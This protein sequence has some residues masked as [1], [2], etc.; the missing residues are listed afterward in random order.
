MAHRQGFT[1]IELTIALVVV[2]IL[3]SVAVNAFGDAQ[4]RMATEQS[5]RL[6]QSLHARARA[7]AVERGTRASLWVDTPGD[8]AWVTRNGETL[9]SVRFDDEFGVEIVGSPSFFR[10]CMGPRG[11]AE[12]SCTSLTG[13]ARLIFSQNQRADTV[14]VLPMGQ[15]VNP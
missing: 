12:L 14:V 6:F 7:Q 15:L 2:A 13:P 11:F 5:V 1:M 8:S 4:N 10:L 9:A 3:L